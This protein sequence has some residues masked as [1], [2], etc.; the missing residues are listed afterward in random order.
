MR[1]IMPLAARLNRGITILG[2]TLLVSSSAEAQLLGPLSETEEIEVGRTAAA[3]IEKE[4]HFLSDDVV[5]SYVSD[6]GQSLA[7][8]SQ[9]SALTYQFKVVDSAEINAFALPGGFIYVNR[10]LIEAAENE[11]KLA[12]G[13]GSRDRACR[14]TPR[15]R[16]GAAGGVCEPWV[17]RAWGDSR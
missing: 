9:R 17:Q 12:G 4:L 13:L 5:T 8:R 11:D 1:P 10:G 15:R 14:G 6:L 3:E 16:A 2:F 7:A